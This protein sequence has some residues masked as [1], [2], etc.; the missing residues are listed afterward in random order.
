DHLQFH[1]APRAASGSG[2]ETCA[3][4]IH[5]GTSR[6]ILAGQ[7]PDGRTDRAAGGNR[8][9]HRPRP[10]DHVSDRQTSDH[11][12]S[13]RRAHATKREIQSPRLPRFPLEEWQRPDRVARMGISRT[14]EDWR[15]IKRLRPPQRIISTAEMKRRIKRIAPLQ[16]GKMLGALYNL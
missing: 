14:D 5:A 12:I 13:R 10:G 2:R 8:V 15:V 6:Q 9:L 7:S 1:A 11:E 16:A 3:R 4:R